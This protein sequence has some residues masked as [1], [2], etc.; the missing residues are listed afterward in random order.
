LELF[1]WTLNLPEIFKPV[2]WLSGKTDESRH[3]IFPLS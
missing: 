1:F 3:W 2:L